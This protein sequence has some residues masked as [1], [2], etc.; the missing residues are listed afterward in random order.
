MTS[1]KLYKLGQSFPVH[2][3][4]GIGLAQ[5]GQYLQI[6]GPTDKMLVSLI[7]EPGYYLADTSA[8]EAFGGLELA[9]SGTLRTSR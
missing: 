3:F 8:M 6:L 9:N 5:N 4:K 2:E 7:L 1:F